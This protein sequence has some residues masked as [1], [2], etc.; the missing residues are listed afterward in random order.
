MANEEIYVFTKYSF[1]DEELLFAVS[2]SDLQLHYI[3]TQLALYAE[4]KISIAADTY[5]SPEVFLRAHEYHRG[6]M[7]AMKYLIEM[8][9]SVSSIIK[10]KAEEDATGRRLDRGERTE[11]PAAISDNYNVN[12]SSNLGH[13]D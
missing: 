3:Q 8:Y 1:T 12:S 4:Q 2:Y 13:G 9:H 11:L 5:E 6:L 10:K 7:D